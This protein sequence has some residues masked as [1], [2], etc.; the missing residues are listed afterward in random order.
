MT[1]PLRIGVV[2]ATGGLGSEV[3]EVLS[4]SSLSIGEL[5]PVATSRSL[6]HDIEFQDRI[7]P[8]LSEPPPLRGLD[9][10]FL[11]AP[12]EASRDYAREALRAEVPCVDAAGALAGSPEVALCIAAFGVAGEQE[13]A[14]LLVAPSGPVLALVL[15]LRP[16]QEAAGLRRIVA[17]CLDAAS[18]GGRG[19]IETL[20]G[21][22]IALFNHEEPPEP[23]VFGRPVAFDCLPALGGVDAAGASDRER[24]TADGL[25]RLLGEEV[26][27][28]LTHLQVPTF[29]GFGASVALETERALDPAL[30][31]GVLGKAPGLER[32]DD[33]AD[34]ATLRAASGRDV[35]LVSRVR[36]DPS[37]ETG[38]LLW[39]ACDTLRLAADN[40]VRLA[41][42]RLGQLH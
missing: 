25:A 37:A 23:E 29:V 12:G 11:C 13:P 30:A 34:G 9:C 22:S 32:W 5:V 41:V 20:Y 26:R 1:G 2:G 39:L 17:T 6:G 40:A 16:L 31:E 18:V 38:L 19:G 24:V 15:A 7:Y 33:A 14:P 8:V 3:L 42:S 28:G 4:A 36:R 27:V 21:E 10:V 35:V